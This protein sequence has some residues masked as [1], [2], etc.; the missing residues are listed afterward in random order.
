MDDY[1]EADFDFD[2]VH[3]TV[4]HKPTG[5]TFQFDGYP[6]P[7]NGNE[8]RVTLD[9]DLDDR[10]LTRLCNAAGLHLKARIHRLRA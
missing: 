6:D 3:F 4:S 1:P 5:S 10:E 8:V 9:G 7:V 2:T